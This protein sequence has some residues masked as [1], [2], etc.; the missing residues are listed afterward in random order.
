MP[1]VNQ[2]QDWIQVV[3]DVGFPIAVSSVCL[4][5][6]VVSLKEFTKALFEFSKALNGMEKALE[7]NTKSISRLEVLLLTGR[8]VG[9]ERL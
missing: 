1:I 7:Q 5:V 6:I 2:S 8:D 3:K 4:W 9:K